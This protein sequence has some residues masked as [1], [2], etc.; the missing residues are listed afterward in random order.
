MQIRHGRITLELHELTRGPGLPLLLLHPLG[1]STRDWGEAP[2]AWPGPVYGLDFSGHGQSEWIKG[3]GYYAELLAGDAD[4]ALMHIGRAALAGAGLGAYVALLLAGARAEH[5]P[6]ALLLP[7]P[8]LAASGPAPDFDTPFPDLVTSGNGHAV[9]GADPMICLLEHDVR[10]P[11]YAAGF[12]VAARA[13]LLA[14]D[15]EP[16]PQWWEALRTLPVARAVSPDIGVA[17]TA[18]AGHVA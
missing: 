17:L 12:G 4:A 16:R 2:A 5:V 6:G 1:S 18:L 3:G 13:L 15:G 9:H 11:D 8:G 10:P 7:G 14:E